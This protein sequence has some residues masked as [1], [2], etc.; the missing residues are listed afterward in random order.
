MVGN[1]DRIQHQ[2]HLPMDL[3]KFVL[4]DIK[5]PHLQIWEKKE[6]NLYYNLF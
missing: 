6:E 1:R 3:L 4:P 5:Q 2:Y